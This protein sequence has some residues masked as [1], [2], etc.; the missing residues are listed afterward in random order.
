MTSHG[1]VYDGIGLFLGNFMK[2]AIK[3]ISSMRQRVHIMPSAVEKKQVFTKEPL[4]KKT[5]SR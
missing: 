5:E 3:A 4:S 1:G 2:E